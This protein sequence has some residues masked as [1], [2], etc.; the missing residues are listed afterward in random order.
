MDARHGIVGQ[1]VQ[2][3]NPPG[4]KLHLIN[5]LIHVSPR[6]ETLAIVGYDFR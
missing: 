3:T 1:A 4:S 5:F 6:I 2:W